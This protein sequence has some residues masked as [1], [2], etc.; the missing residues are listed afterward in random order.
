MNTF[1]AP[2]VLWA[3]AGIV[4]WLAGRY[5]L[6][7]NQQQQLSADIVGGVTWTGAFVTA[8]WV[9]WRARMAAPP[10]GGASEKVLT[11][12]PKPYGSNQQPGPGSGPAPKD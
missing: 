10:T 1:I 12:D 2:I 4:T 7:L 8:M 5:H 11:P 9:H 3:V 6:D